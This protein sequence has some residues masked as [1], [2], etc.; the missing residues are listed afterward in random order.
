[1]DFLLLLAVIVLAGL[2]AWR[3]FFGFAAQPP[4]AYAGT[5]PAM[6]I[7]RNLSG[8]M[9]CQGVIF[10]PT[11]RVTS[12]FVARMVGKWADKTATL[13][14]DFA[15]SGGKTQGRQWAITMGDNGFFTA[16]A[17]DIVGVAQG[18]QSGATARMTYRL[19]LTE[20]AGGHVLDVVDWLYLTDDGTI[21]NK[22]EM[23]K[24]GVKVAELIATIR[25]VSQ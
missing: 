16:T 10:G 14:E 23:R 25:P 20:A 7:S 21:L 8:E 22:S 5:G 24:F 9:I 1:M 15:Y 6:D 13:S 18:Q 17:P 2:F 4:T 12:R 3:F 19:R 11:G